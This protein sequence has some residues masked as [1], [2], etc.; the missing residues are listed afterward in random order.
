MLYCSFLS[1]LFGSLDE[2]LAGDVINNAFFFALNLPLLERQIV[3][4]SLRTF[5]H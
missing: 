2:G 5:D 1:N 4:F 3:L